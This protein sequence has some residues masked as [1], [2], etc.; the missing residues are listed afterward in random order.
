LAVRLSA[1]EPQALPKA[2]LWFPEVTGG[3]LVEDFCSGANLFCTSDHLER[4]VGDNR[5]AGRP[6]TIEEVAEVG[7]VSWADARA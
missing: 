3:H 6:M 7:R 2:A 1:G 5:L 4:W